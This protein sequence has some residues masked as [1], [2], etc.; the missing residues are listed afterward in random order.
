[1]RVVFEIDKG[2]KEEDLI[3]PS[4]KLINSHHE[5]DAPENNWGY[6]IATAF[7]VA[8]IVIPPLSSFVNSLP[9]IQYVQNL[10]STGRY[11]NDNLANRIVKAMQRKGYQL[12]TNL[13]EVNII[14][15]RGADQYGNSNGNRI[16]EWSD[17]RLVLMFRNG[18]PT[19]VGNWAATTKPGL[20]AIKNPTN[21]QG[22]AFIEP[23]QYSAWRV[24]THYGMFG[25]VEL[26][27]VQVA[28]V[29]FRRDAIRLGDV[30]KQPVQ[31]GMIGLN[32]HSGSDQ[33]YVNKASYACLA[34][35]SQNAHLN[36]F[37][38]LV[39]SD[40]RYRRDQNFVL[41][42]TILDVSDI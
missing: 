22:A 17:R 23:G 34:A 25:R 42:T 40:P 38:K 37:M 26:G 31:S 7:L 29:K 9:P 19:I 2:G 27:L 39:M 4:P 1:M 35:Q 16:N 28:P 20:P 8:T 10:V 33:Q 12:S 32:Q 21:N 24:G 15:L 6:A 18:Q 3:V 11:R 13:D 36:K 14:Y 30:S 5:V 41:A